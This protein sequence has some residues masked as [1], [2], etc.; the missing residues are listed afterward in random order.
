LKDVP[1]QTLREIEEFFVNYH[2]LQGKK[3]KPLA[4]KGPKTAFELV[5]LARKKAR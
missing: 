4:R 3:F 1:E 5:A 2:K